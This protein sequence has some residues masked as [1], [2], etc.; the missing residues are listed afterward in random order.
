GS[1][2]ARWHD[3]T[4]RVSVDL[5][6]QDTYASLTARQLESIR[7][8]GTLTLLPI[9][10]STHAGLCVTSG[11]FSQV[12]EVLEEAD[13]ITTATSECA[14]GH[15]SRRSRRPAAAARRPLPPTQL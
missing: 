6:D 10:L 4:S 15:W 12:A 8:T 9:A 2:V 7:A 11:K 5:F 3:I 14:A 13:V 1:A